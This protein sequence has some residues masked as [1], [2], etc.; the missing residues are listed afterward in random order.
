[1]QFDK[2]ENFSTDGMQVNLQVRLS[3]LN[4]LWNI[5]ETDGQIKS[6]R[7]RRSIC[8]ERGMLYNCVKHK[9]GTWWLVIEIEIK[10][11]RIDSL[12]ILSYLNPIFP[13][14]ING[15]VSGTILPLQAPYNHP[16]SNNY[17]KQISPCKNWIQ[18]FRYRGYILSY[19][20]PKNPE[21]L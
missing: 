15:Q 2:S 7:L 21:L 18:S 4:I 13:V 1:M 3:N 20:V 12:F 6:K 9:L 11:Y 8:W 10:T 14:I 16:L 19:I 5:L 17:H